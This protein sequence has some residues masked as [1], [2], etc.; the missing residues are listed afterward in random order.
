MS[1]FSSQGLPFLL[2]GPPIALCGCWAEFCVTEGKQM[3]LAEES[4]LCGCQA[5]TRLL[6]LLPLHGLLFL[7]KQSSS[8]AQ[9]PS[10]HWFPGSHSFVPPA[11]VFGA[12]AQVPGAAGRRDWVTGTPHSCHPPPRYLPPLCFSVRVVGSQ[13]SVRRCRRGVFSGKGRASSR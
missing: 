11:A 8:P 9:T 5:Q 1:S 6:P 2:N 10:Q 3:P 4:V 13:R 7:R 12:S